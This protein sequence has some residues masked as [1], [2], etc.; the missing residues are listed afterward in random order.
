METDR[1]LAEK[2][3]IDFEEICSGLWFTHGDVLQIQSVWHPKTDIAQ[4]FEYVVPK[5]RERG[6]AIML[7]YYC[8]GAMDESL[9]WQWY[10]SF[11]I[12]GGPNDAG[13]SHNA[14]PAAAICAA[15]RAALE[16]EGE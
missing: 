6:Y 12:D 5:M 7:D 8:E 14:D 10:V 3:G 4:C 9:G 13:A 1:F 11:Y 2:L 15:A 16:S